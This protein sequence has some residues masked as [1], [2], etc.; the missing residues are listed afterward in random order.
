MERRVY[1]RLPKYPGEPVV[2]EV[3]EPCGEKIKPVGDPH[4]VIRLAERGELK[5][6]CPKHSDHP[7]PIEDQRALAEYSRAEIAGQNPEP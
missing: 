7:I 1:C 2:G 4:E 5:G 3:V 6:W